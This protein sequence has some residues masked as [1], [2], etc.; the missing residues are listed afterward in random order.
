ML[1]A[2]TLKLIRE[3]IPPLI[4]G[5][6]MTQE[7]ANLIRRS[8]PKTTGYKSSANPTGQASCSRKREVNCSQ[9]LHHFW[10]NQ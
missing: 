7:I 1:H 6:F 9:L 2:K 10:Q 5:D 3:T 8:E 4:M